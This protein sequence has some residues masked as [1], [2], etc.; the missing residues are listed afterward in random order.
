MERATLQRR[1][2]WQVATVTALTQETPF[3]RTIELGVPDWPG[4]RAGQHLDV[5]LTAEDGYS[6]ERSYSVA[7]APGEPLAIT[8][9]CLADGEVSPYLTQDLQ[10]GDELELRGP[11]GGYFV[12]EAS[13]G[14]PLLLVAGGSGIVPLRSMLRERQRTGSQ[15]PVRLLYSSRTLD[16]VIYRDELDSYHDGVSVTHALTRAQPAGW[17]GHAGRVTPALL[18]EVAWPA[19]EGPLAF[20]CGP[21]SFVEA[22]AQ[23][24]V[25]LG[26]PT[27]RI[28]T[29][30][31]GASG[32]R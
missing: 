12:W 4:H 14:G 28:K 30:R 17:T 32:G 22:M 20:A 11:V 18:R 27:G 23:G 19:E 7:S 13:T 21:T 15:V 25:G 26:Y 31:F 16:D 2:T 10:V 6:A 5:R 3:V 8:V 1:L 29:E 9:E 24:L